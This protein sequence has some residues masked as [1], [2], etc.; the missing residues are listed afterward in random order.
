LSNFVEVREQ[1]LNTID[2][3]S[4]ISEYIALKP[5]G[6]NYQGLCPFHNEKT[7]SFIV[8]PVKQIFKCFGCG[9][10]GTA[11][12]FIKKMNALNYFEAIKYLADK[13]NIALPKTQYN[14]IADQDKKKVLLNAMEAAL[15]FFKSELKKNIIAQ[16]YLDGRGISD[17]MRALFAI[18]YAPDSRD[19]LKRY[20]NNRGYNDNILIECGLIIN[21]DNGDIFDR[22]RNRIQ[23]PIFD[24]NNQPIA[25]GGR[26]L[27]SSKDFKYLNS[28]ET[29]I[30]HK[31]S[32][33][34]GLNLSKKYI[35]S[36]DCVYVLEGYIDL[37]AC[38]QFNIKNVVA[39]LGTALTTQQIRLIKRF[40]NNVIMLYDGDEA[41]VEAMARSIERLLEQDIYPDVYI[42]PDNMDPADVLL[43]YGAEY[44]TN[45]LKNKKS[46]FEFYL[47]K[48]M[49]ET[50]TTTVTG[51]KKVIDEMVN[52]LKY[53]N[54]QLALSEY[55]KKISE[56]LDINYDI[57]YSELKRK[58]RIA[59]SNERLY[60]K[61]SEK[62]TAANEKENLANL[63]I[64]LETVEAQ[65]LI[66]LFDNALPENINKLSKN[67]DL[68]FIMPEFRK[69]F[70]LIF[71]RQRADLHFLI[72]EFQDTPEIVHLLT[73]LSIIEKTY[74]VDTADKILDELISAFNRK[75]NN[76]LSKQRLEEIKA[77]SAAVDIDDDTNFDAMQK[78]SLKIQEQINDK[79]KILNLNNLK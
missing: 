9:E 52:I 10:G 78:L 76:I 79:K 40:T 68:D 2:I 50:A 77:Q 27:D 35:M 55:I 70:E 65:I 39:T 30:Y 59:K 38:F 7:P 60:P 26:L 57:L 14:R 48:A 44:F 45:L 41:G 6:V 23:F 5:A 51:K 47:L 24:I 61:N 69:I 4:L 71:L 31:G 3:V 22:F 67:I 63:K 16:K 21:K 73:S 58:I 62:I 33:L 37:I 75:K 49:S 1:L 15:H 66:F 18:G 25:F 17:E 29:L 8:S 19:A 43:N 53:I 34:Y 20:L 56:L 32:V 64:L 42:I 54:D 13:Y 46:F 72:L 74:T 28:P 36:A 11:I 12:D